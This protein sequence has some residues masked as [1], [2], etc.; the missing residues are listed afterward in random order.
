MHSPSWAKQEAKRKLKYKK[1]ENCKNKN[2]LFLMFTEWMFYFQLI[3]D[4]DTR[5]ILLEKYTIVKSTNKFS[6]C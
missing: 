4:N 3:K 2:I 5:L 6:I 1:K